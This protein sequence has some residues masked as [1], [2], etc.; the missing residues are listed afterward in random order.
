LNRSELSDD[1]VQK[2]RSHLV[3]RFVFFANTGEKH[4]VIRKLASTLISLYWKPN[5]S[6][7]HILWNLGVC[8]LQQTWVPEAHALRVQFEKD[9]LPSLNETQVDALLTFAEIFAEEAVKWSTES[10]NG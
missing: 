6:W 9:V 2:L 8:L 5:T 1:D 7:R 4:F 3:S 10:R